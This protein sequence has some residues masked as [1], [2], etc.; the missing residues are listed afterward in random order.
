MSRISMYTLEAIGPRDSEID[1]ARAVRML[2]EKG[3]S[4]THGDVY[5][6]KN[7]SGKK[8]RDT[9]WKRLSGRDRT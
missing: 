9:R 6:D 4:P 2:T 1:R 8:T 3:R 5:D 7:S